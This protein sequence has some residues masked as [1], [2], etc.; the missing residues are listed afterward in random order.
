MRFFL[1]ACCFILR[2]LL[3]SAEEHGDG[4]RS[5][6][7]VGVVLDLNSPTGALVNSSMSMALSD[8]Y[9]S[10]SDYRTR[11]VLDTV[12]VDT[13]L[14]AVSAGNNPC[15]LVLLCNTIR[16]AKIELSCLERLCVSIIYCPLSP[17]ILV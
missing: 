5:I 14:E 13:E 3:V 9:S 12:D 16:F 10:H 2:I 15:Y 4:N 6:I 1:S 11:L 7:K 17:Q 8:F